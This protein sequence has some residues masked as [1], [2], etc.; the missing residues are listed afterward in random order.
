MTVVAGLT[1]E[2]LR[3]LLAQLKREKAEK[4]GDQENEVGKTGERRLVG[5]GGERTLP[6]VE[7]R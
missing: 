3:F 4:E 6:A 5:A 2:E 1:E 7:G